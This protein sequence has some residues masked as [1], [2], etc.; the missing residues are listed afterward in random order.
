MVVLEES[1]DSL[2]EA[3]ILVRELEMFRAAPPILRGDA[4][5][6][7]RER[8]RDDLVLAVTI[9]AWLGE[10]ALQGELERAARD[11]W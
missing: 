5:E 11:R 4:V 1:A 8:P 9:A 3:P 10:E 6:S 2:P 7:W